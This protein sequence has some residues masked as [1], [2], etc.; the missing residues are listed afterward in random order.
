MTASD[1]FKSRASAA[2]FRRHAAHASVAA[3]SGR[4]AT[5]EAAA[6]ASGVADSY[7]R[8]SFVFDAPPVERR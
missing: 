1:A 8:R 4:A 6:A 3:T 2:K 5:S 7:L